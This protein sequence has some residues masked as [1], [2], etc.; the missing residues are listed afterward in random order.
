[1]LWL[2][3][4]IAFGLD[5]LL[6]DPHSKWHPVAM[7]GRLA[8]RT[9]KQC[10]EYFGNTVFAGGLGWFLLVGGCT[11]AAWGIGLLTGYIGAGVILYGCIALRSLVEHTLAVAR[12]LDA[13]DLPAARRALGMVVSRD[14]SV[15][16]ENGMIRGALE[17]ISENL[18]DAVNS[19]IFW[20]MLGGVLFGAP[21][22][23]AG[24]VLLRT[25]NTLDACWGYRDERYLK[26]GRI[27]ARTD[28]FMH[29]IPARLTALAVAVASGHFRR[30]L[31][32]AWK[33][34]HHHPSPNSCWGMAAF[35]G[36]LGIRLGGPTAYRDGTEP[37]P[38]WG[39]GRATL[40]IKDLWNAARLCLISV[41]VFLL[42]L[43]GPAIFWWSGG[44]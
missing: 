25:V 41:P 26:F 31:G 22:A 21:G 20:A 33:H 44:G 19:A 4:L 39:D 1:M 34:R 2:T 8:E 10:R 36:A 23:A 27:A 5:L 35:A 11:A 9:E 29:W 14:T 43:S 17:S 40:T 3:F 18:I 15:L 24:A 30:T 42:F 13:G 6:G 12:P 37:Y 38:Y 7:F 28:D 16:D 32:T